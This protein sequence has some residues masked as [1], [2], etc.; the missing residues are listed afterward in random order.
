MDNSQARIVIVGGGHGGGNMAAMLRQAGHQGDIQLI[1]DEAFL[2]YHRPPLS[3]AFLKGEADLSSL[4]L[5]PD[6]F[7]AKSNINVRLQTRVE[8]IDADARRLTLAGGAGLDYD[9]L[10]LATGSTARRL[11]VPG[12]EL[13]GVH[14]LRT[15]ADAQ[16]FRAA[17]G[18]GKR[19]A[20]IG[21]G[22]IGLEAAAS[23]RSLGAEAIVIERE[24]RVLARVACET[25]STFFQTYHSAR[26][27]EFLTGV[28][29]DSLVGGADG[30]V[31]AVKLGDGRVIACDAVLVGVGGAPCD[32]LARSTGL[33]CDNGVIVDLAARTSMPGIYAIGD[34]TSRPLP[35]YG[36][37]MFRLESVPNAVDQAR[38]AAAAIMGKPLPEPDVPW[39]WSDQY[40]LKL[41]IAGVAFDA[42][43]TVVRGSS[44]HAPFSI[45]HLAGE[46]V[47][48]VEAIGSA[49]DFMA[50]KK[51]IASGKPVDPV[52]LANTAVSIKELV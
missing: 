44:E 41:Q 47:V 28:S 26:G 2:P 1:C 48:S 37:R 24:S 33:A 14:M 25:L 19:L 45:W 43:R 29:V 10:I 35:H 40:D 4:L 51:L 52:A 36:N 17:L 3:K 18:Q 9:I 7:Y 23:A 38:A 12:A 8:S 39:F 34:M 49:T 32:E 22:Y 31:E 30:F 15:I 6:T 5:R 46:R 16:G 21:G 27:V 50:G 20:I 42:D 13:G 11:P